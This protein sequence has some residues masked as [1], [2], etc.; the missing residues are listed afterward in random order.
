ME[1]KKKIHTD[2]QL[3]IKCIPY[4]FF[5]TSAS[6]KAVIDAYSMSVQGFFIKETS[7]KE[8]EKTIRTIVEY[9]KR[10]FSPNQY[11]L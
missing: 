5:T 1:L 4:L 7:D 2:A 11:P 6:K 10:C 3:Q 8:L 9:W